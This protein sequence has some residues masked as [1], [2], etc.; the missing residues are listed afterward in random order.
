M[1]FEMKMRL[2]IWLE[3]SPGQSMKTEP[4]ASSRGGK[5]PDTALKSAGIFKRA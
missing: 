5:E 3:S 4:L 1:F 2:A